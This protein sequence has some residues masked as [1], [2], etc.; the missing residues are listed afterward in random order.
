MGGLAGLAAEVSFRIFSD[1]NEFHHAPHALL[2]ISWLGLKGW[3]WLFIIEGIP[4]VLFGIVTIFYL[5]DWPEKAR[6]ALRQSNT[7]RK[8]SPEAIAKLSLIR[9]GR[10]SS[11]DTK[12]KISESLKGRPAIQKTPDG[13]ARLSAFHKGRV[14]GPMSDEHKAKI[15]AA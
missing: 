12:R 2:G 7:G 8:Q 4:A 10:V 9:K 13:I 3:R 6:E 11:D 5:T 15:K 14:V 1:K